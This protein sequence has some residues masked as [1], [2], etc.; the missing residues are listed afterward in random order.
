MIV[1]LIYFVKIHLVSVSNQMV[2]ST[3]FFKSH[4]SPG[5]K[6]ESPR[7]VVAGDRVLSYMNTPQHFGSIR[8]P[9]LGP[10]KRDAKTN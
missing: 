8:H 10:H 4:T 2:P 5:G 7:G 6:R 1:R 3:Q 9:K